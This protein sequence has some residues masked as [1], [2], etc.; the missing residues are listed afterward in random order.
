MEEVQI[1][2]GSSTDSIHEESDGLYTT[3]AISNNMLTCCKFNR[4]WSRLRFNTN[5]K[6]DTL[7]NNMLEAFN[8]LL[9]DARSKPIITLLEDI[10]LYMM[11]RWASNRLKVSSFEGSICS[12]IRDRLVKELQLTKY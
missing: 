2:D 12:R 6:C 7:V 9:V 5:V 4:Y 11:N 10:R 1:E 3:I 8:N